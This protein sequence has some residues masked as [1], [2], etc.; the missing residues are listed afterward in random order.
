M[1]R[2]NSR[3]VLGFCVDLE[4]VKKV[5]FN[6]LIKILKEQGIEYL[7]E[8]VF[9]NVLLP[10]AMDEFCAN[11]I[12]TNRVCTTEVRGKKINFFQETLGIIWKVRCTGNDLIF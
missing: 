2:S 3:Y 11:F 7:F 4:C 10:L 8:T 12:I 1:V 6:G 5:Q 9:N